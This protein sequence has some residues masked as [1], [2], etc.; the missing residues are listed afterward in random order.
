MTTEE[1]S[2]LAEEAYGR[3]FDPALIVIGR[4]GKPGEGWGRQVFH[5]T[6]YLGRL[7]RGTFIADSTNWP[8]GAK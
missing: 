1:I 3:F 2:A 7:D 5:G 6:Q 8:K 4:Q